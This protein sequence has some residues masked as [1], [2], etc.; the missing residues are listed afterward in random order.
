MSSA[1]TFSIHLEPPECGSHGM[2]VEYHDC[3]RG[4]PG[5]QT[6]GVAWGGAVGVLTP[7]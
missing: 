7:W 3:H 1:P 6:W 4:Y 5:Q 2:V